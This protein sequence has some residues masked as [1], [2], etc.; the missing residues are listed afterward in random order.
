MIQEVDRLNRVISEL[1]EFARPTDLKRRSYDLNVLL[2]RCLQLVHQDAA[3][4]QIDIQAHLAENLCRAVIDPDRMAQCVLNLYLNA[5]EAMAPGGQLTVT[6]E[7][8]MTQEARIEITDTGGGIEPSDLEQIFNPYFTTKSKG[9]GL[10]LAIVHKIVEAH[11]G[12]IQVESASSEG[13]R[14]IIT[15]P[16]GDRGHHK[17]SGHSEKESA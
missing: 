7:Q 12:H 15:L 13:T 10:G 9:T 3:G 8:T 14:F 16:C 2:R 6:S 1:L 5:I 17:D 11:D 4:N